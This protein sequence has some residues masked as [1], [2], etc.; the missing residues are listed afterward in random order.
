M[1]Y[2]YRD[3][4]VKI[5]GCPLQTNNTTLS[6]QANVAPI[7]VANDPNIKGYAPLAGREGT[8]RISYFLT[9]KDPLKDFIWNE[10]GCVT[11]NFAGL[12]FNSGY[13]R[14]YSV[15]AI[16]NNPIAVQAE[17][18]FYDKL[19]GVF[20]PT[21]DTFPHM[22]FLNLADASLNGQN[23]GDTATITRLSYSVV[24]D[25]KP[26]YDIDSNSTIETVYPARI[27]FGERRSI[28]ELSINNLSPE[29]S[30]SGNG[31]ELGIILRDVGNTARDSFNIKGALVS[32]EIVS[33]PSDLVAA[34]FVINQSNPINQ[35]EITGV[36]PSNPRFLDTVHIVGYNFSK[37]SKV[38][39]GSKLIFARVRSPAEITFLA[40]PATGGLITVVTEGGVAEAPNVITI[41]APDFGGLF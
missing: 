18:V 24:N 7:F 15:N 4:L 6:Q 5:N 9:G 13:V 26:A 35:P 8:F 14:N 31:V 38:Y 28:L 22:T 2:T 20:Q 10:S 30:L 11:G 21:W 25:I 29:L 37:G 16:P 17:V 36:I 23:L 32:K 3:C 40:P 19:T 33:T 39:L 27:V 12:Q 34:N 41:D 1:F